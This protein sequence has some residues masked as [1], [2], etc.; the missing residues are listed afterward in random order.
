MKTV[1]INRGMTAD[2]KKS[3]LSNLSEALH[4]EDVTVLRDLEVYQGWGD[5]IHVRIHTG[6]S[7]PFEYRNRLRSLF[8]AAVSNALSPNRHLVEIRW[9]N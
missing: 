2:L 4:D 8:E 7:P 6:I 9:S 5:V 3:V 1:S